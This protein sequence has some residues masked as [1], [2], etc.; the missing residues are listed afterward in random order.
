MWLHTEVVTLGDIPRYWAKRK[1]GAKALI[2]GRRET[3]WAELDGASERIAQALVSKGFS[4]PANIGYL[5]KN[6]AEY[7]KLLFGVVKAGLAIAPLNWRLSVSELVAIIDDAQCPIVFVDAE[8]AG[9]SSRSRHAARRAS[10]SFE[11]M[12]CPARRPTLISGWRLPHRRRYLQFIP[13]TRPF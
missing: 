8:F 11:C 6:S 1:P 3:T 9:I 10:A 4:R 12:P 5:G 13:W 7:F 2:D